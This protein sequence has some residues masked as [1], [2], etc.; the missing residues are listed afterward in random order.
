M[1]GHRGIPRAQ[2]NFSLWV[3]LSFLL[4]RQIYTIL[5]SVLEPFGL[6]CGCLEPKIHSLIWELESIN[7]LFKQIFLFTLRHWCLCWTGWLGTLV[8]LHNKIRSLEQW[9]SCPPPAHS[10]ELTFSG[11]LRGGL[12]EQTAGFTKLAQGLPDSKKL[13]HSKRNFCKEMRNKSR[14]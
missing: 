10:G 5:N 9:D 11:C 13:L 7:M 12:S 6:K 1:V 2:G 14:D 3:S 4:M 8:L